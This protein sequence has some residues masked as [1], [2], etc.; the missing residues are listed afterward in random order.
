MINFGEGNN[1]LGKKLRE[2]VPEYPLH[3]LDLTDFK[4]FE[5][6]QTEL[7]PLLEL[8][9]KRNR[10]EEFIEYLKDERS[11][12]NMDD[13]SWHLLSN[14]TRSKGIKKLV[15]AKSRK[16]E[17][18]GIMCRAIDEWEADCIAKGRSE[19]RSEGRIEAKI[20]DI[21]ELLEDC[22][23]V[24]AELKDYVSSQKDLSLLGRWHKLA[25]R[26]GS[27]EEFECQMNN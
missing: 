7:R 14:L 15:Q 10:K 18:S 13:E 6:F 3:F 8:Y 1:Q 26:A 27:I 17:G 20:E 2:M 23:E 24:S 9:Q 22:G 12:I 11:C 19:G 21:M 16:R 5:H 25:A 4:H